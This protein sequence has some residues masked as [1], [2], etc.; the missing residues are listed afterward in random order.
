MTLADFIRKH[1]HTKFNKKIGQ[2]VIQSPDFK[3]RFTLAEE[4]ESMM[5]DLDSVFAEQVSE[6]ETCIREIQALPEGT[7][8]DESGERCP[9]GVAAQALRRGLHPV[10]EEKD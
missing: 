10:T 8:G 9:W 4:I 7:W 5:K 2:F 3:G 1:G 6:R